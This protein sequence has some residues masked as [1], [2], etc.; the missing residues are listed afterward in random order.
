M[1]VR[2]VDGKRPFWA[3]I[4]ACLERTG[5]QEIPPMRHTTIECSSLACSR[6][7]TT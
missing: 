7:F 2:D 5:S 6:V 3:P 1:T 4:E